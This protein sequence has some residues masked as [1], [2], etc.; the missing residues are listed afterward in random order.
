MSFTPSRLTALLLVA[1][2]ST[3]DLSL[4]NAQMQL[5]SR[6][7]LAQGTM[8]LRIQRRPGGVE[9]VIEGV[10]PQPVLQQRLN[11]RVWQGSLQT[12]G[13]PGILN[14]RQQV[15]DP[16]AGLQ[17]VAITGSGSAY[18]LEVVPGSGQILQEP[19]VSADGRNLILRFPGLNAGPSLQ[20]GRIDLNTP[21]RV[22]Q[23]RYAPPLRPRAVA[24][25]L[26][27]MAVG[28]M[29][30]QNR[31]YVNVSGP[32][33]T[34]TLN[35][36]PAKDALMVLARLGGY[37]FVFLGEKNSSGSASQMSSGQQGMEQRLVS[38]A[39]QQEDFSKAFNSVLMASGLQ[40]RLSGNALFVGEKI[41][42]AGLS[43]T[44]SKV[45][46]LNQVSSD[47]A[48]QYLA[49]LGARVC[50]PTTTTFNSSASSTEGTA[51]ASSSQTQ[52]SSSEKTEISCYGGAQ[53]EEGS[54]S[55]FGP[56]YG[57]EG[58]TDARL[59]TVTLIGESSQVTV[60]EKYLRNLDLRKRQVAIKVQ[61]LNIDLNNDKSIDSSFS[62]RMG[63]TFI[64][65][66]SG[67]AFMNFG[68]YKPGNEAGTGRLG[69][70]TPY[71]TPGTYSAG[72]PMQAAQDVVDPV[73]EASDVV[74]AVVEKNN[75]FSPPFIEKQ[76]EETTS[77]TD[78][79]TGITTVTKTLVPVIEDGQPVY[80]RSNDPMAAPALVPAYDSDGR[81][82]YVPTTDPTAAP[83]LVPRYDSNGQPIYVSSTDPAASQTLV[84]RYDKNGQP[85]YVAG[86]DPNKFS[87]PQNS[88]YG[89]LE[90]VIESSSAKTLASPTL[91]VQEGQA[92]KV[93]TGTS[94]ITGVKATETANGS[95]QFENTRENA[96]LTLDVN[97][98]KIDDNGFVTMNISPTISIPE[99]AGEQRGVPIFNITGRSLSSG[100]VRLR[101]RQTLVLTGVIRETDFAQVTKWP[102]LG[103]LPI[104]GQLFRQSISGKDKQELV[105]LVT[106][107]IVDD[108]SGG[109]Y[110]YGYRP[111]TREARQLMGPR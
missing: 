71:S 67:K 109:A 28:T 78:S 1:G 101:D 55:G 41:S 4:W 69:N 7:A 85:V 103:D 3:V 40:G 99:G 5:G 2:L 54:N 29:V 104:L 52:S 22:P 17:R 57:L 86:K 14:G 111:S 31:N 92:A 83:S 6:A 33:V 74:G 16:V 27:D 68:D 73:V 26:G 37:G 24:P 60:A 81:R 77:V 47:S 23:S 13:N 9:V 39:F 89:Y 82:V 15:S 18:R 87:Y 12:Q 58:T 80:V 106:P 107:S 110:G 96:G 98:D 61:I 48:A 36:A 44:V 25:P 97:V 72:V 53:D 64:V 95:T 75:V 100:R 59:S 42:Y 8:S 21:G 76:R 32:P 50:V 20:T 105:I 70:N 88:F 94:V 10:G 46:R 30:L 93:E 102:I 11:G 19:V 51:S 79:N 62:A 49:S 63:N 35:N 56:L 45:F 66:Q 34:L 108:E 84:P 90:A 91:L 65:S 38:L 43:P